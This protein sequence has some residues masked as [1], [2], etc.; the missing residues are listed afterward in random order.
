MEKFA[1]ILY[2]K[3]L[4]FWQII[5]HL[6]SSDTSTNG[7]LLSCRFHQPKLGTD[8][9]SRMLQKRSS[10]EVYKKYFLVTLTLSLRDLVVW[11][12]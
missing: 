10:A 6:F 7:H 1:S 11:H 2:H 12:R 5:F 4:Y 3:N 8:M 9:V